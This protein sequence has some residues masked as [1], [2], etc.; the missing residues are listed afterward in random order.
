LL[1]AER[2]VA[3]T[4]LGLSDACCLAAFIFPRSGIEYVAL[5]IPFVIIAAVYVNRYS[6]S[7]LFIRH[8]LAPDTKTDQII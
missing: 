1:I 3:F 4:W 5:V 6:L 7:P 8:V 2:D